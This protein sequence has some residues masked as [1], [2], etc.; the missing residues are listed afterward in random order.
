V[1]L[2]DRK[3]KETYRLLVNRI[4]KETKMPLVHRKTKAAIPRGGMERNYKGCWS[5]GN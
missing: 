2:V 3:T 5:I 4:A 1:V